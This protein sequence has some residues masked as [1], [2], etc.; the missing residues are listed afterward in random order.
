MWV[1]AGRWQTLGKFGLIVH[2]NVMSDK[3][4]N[5]SDEQVRATPQYRV[6][7]PEGE[8]SAPKSAQNTAETPAVT[9]AAPSAADAKPDG[10][11]KAPDA[12]KEIGGPKG[13]E[14][15]RFGDWERDGRCVDF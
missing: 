1:R 7:K 13:L 15:T 8:T 3:H 12:P 14:P 6:R 5:P 4:D 11:D 2:I 10:A 9:S